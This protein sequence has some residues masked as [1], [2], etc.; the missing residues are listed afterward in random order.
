MVSAWEVYINNSN[1]N[2]ILTDTESAINRMKTYTKSKHYKILLK[3]SVHSISGHKSRVRI[4]DTIFLRTRKCQHFVVYIP[5]QSLIFQHFSLPFFSLFYFW[6]NNMRTF[7][8][9]E[10]FSFFSLILWCLFF[11]GKFTVL[12]YLVLQL[13][14]IFLHHIQIG[15]VSMPVLNEDLFSK[16][17]LYLILWNFYST[18]L[19]FAFS[20]SSSLKGHGIFTGENIFASDQVALQSFIL[21]LNF[22]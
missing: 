3:P 12:L 9:Q 5:V 13:A 17:F 18:H 19:T 4:L 10:F 15:K 14:S 16:L 20:G 6:V 11:Y 2:F 1:N 7:L 8:K 22:T 21:P